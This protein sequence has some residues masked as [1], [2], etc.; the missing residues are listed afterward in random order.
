MRDNFFSWSHRTLKWF[1]SCWFR[2]LRTIPFYHSLLMNFRYHHAVST[3][4]NFPIHWD[5]FITDLSKDFESACVDSCRSLLRLVKSG[6]W[7]FAAGACG[8]STLCSG[9]QLSTYG[10]DGNPKQWLRLYAL[11]KNSASPH[12]NELC[13]HMN[14]L[15]HPEL[16][17]HPIRQG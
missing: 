17:Q 13:C 16:R 7:R 1:H 12:L 4:H 9:F 14:W 11:S 5:Q 6:Y 10:N 15:Y 2:L 8:L 3:E